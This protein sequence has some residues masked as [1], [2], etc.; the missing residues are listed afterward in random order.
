MK[1]VEQYYEYSWE[2]FEYE[3]E[4]L[5]RTSLKSLTIRV[6]ATEQLVSVVQCFFGVL[7]VSGSLQFQQLIALVL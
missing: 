7:T 5:L 1:A 2:N 6:K 3:R 4:V